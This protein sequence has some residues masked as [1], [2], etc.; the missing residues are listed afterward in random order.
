MDELRRLV[1]SDHTAF[2][3]THANGTERPH[4]PQKALVHNGCDCQKKQACSH[5]IITFLENSLWFIVSK[6]NKVLE[7]LA[8]ADQMG[9]F[10]CLSNQPYL[11]LSINLNLWQSVVLP[12]ALLKFKPHQ[13]DK[14]INLF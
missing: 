5:P 9:L 14:C 6:I 4:E 10:K 12:T 7:L 13:N 8:Q 1:S 11:L 3:K 2:E